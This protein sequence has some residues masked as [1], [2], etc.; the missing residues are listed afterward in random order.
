MTLLSLVTWRLFL[1]YKLQ[2]CLTVGPATLLLQL[3]A[4]PK[5][6]SLYW[7]VYT[8]G[9]HRSV[10]SREREKKG[11]KTV[12]YVLM[13]CLLPRTVSLKDKEAGTFIHR[14]LCSM[15]WGLHWGRPLHISGLHL[16]VAKP[17]SPALEKAVQ[18]TVVEYWE[19]CMELSTMRV[20]K[21]GGLRVGNGS[22]RVSSTDDKKSYLR[23]MVRLMK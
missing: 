15:A 8:E 10:E 4:D 16:H 5:T 13:S 19:R 1:T 20:L 11:R 22:L 6:R 17:S 7:G 14:L 3:K 18:K 9:S 2:L 23:I 21:L 12:K